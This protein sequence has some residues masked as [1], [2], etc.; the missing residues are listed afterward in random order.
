V[1]SHSDT[2]RASHGQDR[3]DPPGAVSNQNQEEAE[4]GHAAS[5]EKSGSGAEGS[6]GES[7]A[8]AP[9]DSGGSTS[10]AASEGSQATGHPENAG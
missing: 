5:G 10:G 7:G 8:P 9:A 6:S 2:D 3:A 1:S 4:A